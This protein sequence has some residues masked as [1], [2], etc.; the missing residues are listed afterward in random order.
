VKRPYRKGEIKVYYKKMKIARPI[1]K[2]IVII[3]MKRVAFFFFV[4]CLLLI[5]L[6]ILGNTQ[7]FMDKTGRMTL[8]LMSA[9]GICLAFSS[10]IG[11]FCTLLMFFS[12][13]F[14]YIGGI[15]IYAS[16]LLFGV[17]AAVLSSSILILADGYGL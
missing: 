11:I 13:R 4:M 3:L 15:V 14:R 12:G 2:P 7:N 8:G 16:L 5:L 9:A 1:Q 17:I 10:T 6:Y